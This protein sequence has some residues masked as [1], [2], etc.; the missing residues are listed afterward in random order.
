MYARDRFG[1]HLD[2]IIRLAESRS[3]RSLRVLHFPFVQGATNLYGENLA[4]AVSTFRVLGARLLSRSNGDFPR[5]ISR[6]LGPDE[7]AIN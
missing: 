7:H 3:A 6:V 2:F 5:R 1:P 4:A